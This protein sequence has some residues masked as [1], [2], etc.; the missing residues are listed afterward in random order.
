MVSR[1]DPL[2]FLCTFFQKTVHKGACLPESSHRPPPRRLLLHPHDSIFY[3]FNSFQ[4][5]LLLKIFGC[6][7]PNSF[8]YGHFGVI[9]FLSVHSLRPAMPFEHYSLLYLES[10]HWAVLFLRLQ[11]FCA[12]SFSLPSN[13]RGS[14]LYTA[15]GSQW[16][17]L[18]TQL[19]FSWLFFVAEDPIL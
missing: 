4:I 6:L 11:D 15:L 1:Y 12:C 7:C 13:L 10:L 3:L 8:L 17:N 19:S 16:Y 5:P 18:R 14:C 2:L 9:A